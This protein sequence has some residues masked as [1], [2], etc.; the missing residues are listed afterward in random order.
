MEFRIDELVLNGN[1]QRVD[2]DKIDYL[3]TAKRLKKKKMEGGKIICQQKIRNRM[4]LV[5]YE[6][7]HGLIQC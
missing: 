2:K 6:N 7:N 4:R 3:N 1:S 5:F